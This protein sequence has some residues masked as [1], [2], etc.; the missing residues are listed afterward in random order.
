MGI[1]K[2][3]LSIRGRS[4]SSPAQKKLSS[5]YFPLVTERQKTAINVLYP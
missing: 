2:A 1:Q 4:K 3:F 5:H